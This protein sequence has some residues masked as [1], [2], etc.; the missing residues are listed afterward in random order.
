MQ[1][2]PSYLFSGNLFLL[3]SYPFLRCVMEECFLECGVLLKLYAPVLE[4]MPVAE[5]SEIIMPTF[6]F[7]FFKFY[8]Y[9]FFFK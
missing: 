5:L 8:F 1:E 4:T 3:S 2:R 7:I 9:A 6:S